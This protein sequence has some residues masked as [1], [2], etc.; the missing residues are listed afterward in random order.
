M[1][2]NQK[3]SQEPRPA[4][5]PGWQ[6]RGLVGAVLLFI[7]IPSL[8]VWWYWNVYQPAPMKAADIAVL[9]AHVAKSYPDWTVEKTYS[10]YGV[11][12]AGGG[13]RASVLL[14]WKGSQDFRISVEPQWQTRHSTG[15]IVPS[16][17][18]PDI[19]QNRE[20]ATGAIAAFV[21]Q[22]PGKSWVADTGFPSRS[23]IQQAGQGGQAMEIGYR[24]LAHF[25][26][27]HGALDSSRVRDMYI[28]DWHATATTS[29]IAWEYLST[30]SF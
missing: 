4:R 11:G 7:V 15:Q 6:V 28:D 29:G 19:F 30:R 10:W 16:P 21:A 3:P 22:H 23:W 13:W 5:K 27:S 9:E 12:L 1:Q 20:D 8:V 17:L 18:Q 2:G 14:R 25:A 24:D 26:S